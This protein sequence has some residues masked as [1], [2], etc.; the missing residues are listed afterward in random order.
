MAEMERR[1]IIKGA[2]WA[3]PVIAAA[4]AA[5]LATASGASEEQLA[6]IGTN[7][8]KKSLK[9]KVMNTGTTTVKNVIVFITW[10]GGSETV[11]LGD[12]APKGHAPT[13]HHRDYTFPESVSNVTLRAVGEDGVTTLAQ[14]TVTR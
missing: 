1:T 11:A 14:V 6:F 2:A 8:T 3:L 4:V 12:I 5:P 9:F 7:F 13:E 10:N